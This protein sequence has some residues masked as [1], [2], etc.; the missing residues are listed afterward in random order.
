MIFDGIGG[1]VSAMNNRKAVLDIEVSTSGFNDVLDKI[2]RIGFFAR[3][4]TEVF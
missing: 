3:V 4:E 1:S 2:V